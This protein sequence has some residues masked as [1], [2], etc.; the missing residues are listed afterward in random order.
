MRVT[1]SALFFG[2]YPD[3]HK[4]LLQ[5]FKTTRW[6]QNDQVRLNFWS[7]QVPEATKNFIARLQLPVSVTLFESDVNVPKYS[8]MRKLFAEEKAKDVSDWLVWF[9]DDTIINAPNWMTETLAY[10]N[11]TPQATYL[12]QPWGWTWQK[13]QVEFIAKSKW[14]KGVPHGVDKGRPTVTFAQ[15]SYWWLKTEAAR[16]LDWPDERLVHNGGDTLL[17]EAVRQQ[18]WPFHKFYRGIS[19]NAARRRGRSDKPAGASA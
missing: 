1:I 17:G 8:V 4:R 9:D 2:N 14:Y 13:G 5:G 3:L 6:P 18:G 16:Q 11:K 15:G 19:P 7:N 12:G 10:I